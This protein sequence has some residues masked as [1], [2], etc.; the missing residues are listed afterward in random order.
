MP[1][2]NEFVQLLQR[3]GIMRLQPEASY[4]IVCGLGGIGRSICH[5]MADHGAKHI[6]VLSRSAAASGDSGAFIRELT[7]TGVIV[8]P[9]ACDASDAEKLSNAITQYESQM[10]KI[11]GVIQGAMVLVVNFESP[12]EATISLIRFL[13]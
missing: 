11:R 12:S 4:L 3:R 1:R 2:P 5:W 7:S 6:A 13:F 10:P 9:I 8:T